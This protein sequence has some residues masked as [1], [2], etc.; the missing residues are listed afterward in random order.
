[1]DIKKHCECN[2]FSS[3]IRVVSL[4][5]INMS[6]NGFKNK[7]NILKNINN[8][9]FTTFVNVSVIMMVQIQLP[10]SFR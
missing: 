6:L 8:F 10:A 4:P 5:S 9:C 7:L 2:R 3:F 1:M